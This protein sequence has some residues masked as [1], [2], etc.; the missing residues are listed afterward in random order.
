MRVLF[1]P[2]IAEAMG[3]REALSWTKQQNLQAIVIETDCPVLVQAL[4]SSGNLRSYFGRIIA[5]CKSLLVELSDRRVSV[6]YIKRSANN[7]WRVNDNH[8]DFIDVLM[9]DLI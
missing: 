1:L 7:S 4:R 2:E 8:L 9:K 5:E 3:V 6:F